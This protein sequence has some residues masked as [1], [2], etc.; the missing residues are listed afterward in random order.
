MEKVNS[1]VTSNGIRV[2]KATVNEKNG[3]VYAELPSDEE[4]EK[5]I[6]LL[7]SLQGNTVVKVNFKMPVIQLRNVCNFIDK[8]NFVDNV[9]LQTQNWVRK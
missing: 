3:D 7:G 9:K 4:R 2:S 8:E 6:P 5:L 1:V